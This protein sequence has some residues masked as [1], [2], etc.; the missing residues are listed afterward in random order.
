M[1]VYIQNQH[2]GEFILINEVETE[3][4][5]NKIIANHEITH[6]Y[7]QPFWRHWITNGRTYVDVGSW[8]YLFV[9]TEE[10]I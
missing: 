2:T 5:A 4:E 10:K 8:S 3:E 9:K 7:N 6:K 1:F